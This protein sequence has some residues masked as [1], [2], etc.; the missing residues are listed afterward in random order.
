[1]STFKPLLLILAT[2]AQTQQMRYRN[3]IV[4]TDNT[5]L[6]HLQNTYSTVPRIA[7]KD[8][9]KVVE[10]ESPVVKRKK[11]E[12]VKFVIDDSSPERKST[13]SVLS[14]NKPRD[15]HVMF[16]N[17]K[18]AISGDEPKKGEGVRHI[19][20]HIKPKSFKQ[21]NQPINTEELS[22]GPIDFSNLEQTPDKS[23]NNIIRQSLLKNMMLGQI[24]P[25][26]TMMM[27][28]LSNLSS[29]NGFSNSGT[30]QLT[31]NDTIN[32]IKGELKINNVNL[33]SP[34]RIAVS[35]PMKSESSI[36]SSQKEQKLMGEVLNQSFNESPLKIQTQSSMNQ[37]DLEL[38]PVK[39]EKKVKQVIR[40]RKYI[41]LERM[42]CGQCLND[43]Y[44]KLGLIL[45]PNKYPQNN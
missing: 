6:S 28:R 5:H 29:G 33:A 20:E 22:H 34:K 40:R 24:H 10:R 27:Q 25:L 4:T 15:L 39:N 21:R 13:V 35:S 38:S 18:N 45:L 9:N 11:G 42:N 43:I 31:A 3:N 2:I 14:Q 1:M 44:L 23:K 32:K 26:N 7:L 19:I 30:K 41:V 16:E 17:Y 37:S 36:N 12:R 8:P